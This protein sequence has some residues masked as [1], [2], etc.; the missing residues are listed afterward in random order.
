MRQRKASVDFEQQA[1]EESNIDGETVCSKTDRKRCDV[2]NSVFLGCFLVCVVFLFLCH[3]DLFHSWMRKT[4]KID[5]SQVES[6]TV[7]C[8]LIIP[9]TLAGFLYSWKASCLSQGQ[10]VLCLPLFKTAVYRSDLIFWT[11]QLV[12]HSVWL[13]LRL[14]HFQQSGKLKKSGILK[15]T[16]KAL[17]FNSLLALVGRTQY[18]QV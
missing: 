12:I 2:L 5:K 14:V 6:V 1:E 7:F 16:A 9:F 15:C 3:S 17:G 4:Y 8:F 13:G 10:R 18:R 11:I